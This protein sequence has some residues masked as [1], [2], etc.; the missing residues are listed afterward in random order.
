MQGPARRAFAGF[1]AAVLLSVVMMGAWPALANDNKATARERFT[2]LDSEIQAVKQEVLEINEEIL[3]LEEQVLYPDRQQLLVFLSLSGNRQANVR[4]ISLE[5]DGETVTRHVYTK[6]EE[7]ALRSGGIHRLYTGRL[8][9][10]AHEVGAVL[11]GVNTNGQQFQ[12]RQSVKIIKGSD[13]KVMELSIS[14]G[15]NGSEPE[16]TIHEW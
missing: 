6:S 9:G 1:H 4:S 13:R 16:F 5:L 2:E 3:S 14:A 15:N 7:A 8:S 11:S 12:R 10:G